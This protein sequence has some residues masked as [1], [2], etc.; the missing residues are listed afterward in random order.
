MKPFNFNPAG[1]PRYREAF[2]LIELLVVI[3]IISLFAAILFPVFSL[4]RENGR[5]A[6][7]MNNLKQIGTGV[8]QYEQDYD[9]R[10]P[11]QVN[12][13][14]NFADPT[15][16]HNWYASAYPYIKSWN[17]FRCPSAMPYPNVSVAPSGNSDS[18]YFLNAVIA[19]D[20]MTTNGRMMSA[21]SN[22]AG[23][24]QMQE[25]TLRTLRAAMR[26]KLYATGYSL[27]IY[28][29]YD[30]GYSSIHFNGGNL[31]YCDGHVKWRK[32]ST[33]C[34]SDWGIAT[35]PSG[36]ACGL[37]TSASFATAAPGAF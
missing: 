12:D 34:A 5:R 33:L 6:S 37:N 27:Y 16:P 15:A 35:P 30:T 29:L 28:W 10:M 32:Q 20:P 22:P 4:A 19:C 3:A 11:S 31:L 14:D 8:L 36:P 24:I 9:E 13:V 25:H 18:N 2:T 21:I 1:R 23:V 7:C 26:P 17:V